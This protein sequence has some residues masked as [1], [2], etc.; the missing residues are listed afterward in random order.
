MIQKWNEAPLRVRRLAHS[1]KRDTRSAVAHRPAGSPMSMTSPRTTLSFDHNAPLIHRP[2]AVPHPYFAINGVAACFFGAICGTQGRLLRFHGM[3][4][5]V[6]WA[7][8]VAS[9]RGWGEGDVHPITSFLSAPFLFTMCR[10]RK[11]A[12]HKGPD[13]WRKQFSRRINRIPLAL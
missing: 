9:D 6:Q 11:Q 13:D 12:P 7:P 10:Y 1:L 5:L 3:N 8:I 2:S 4:L